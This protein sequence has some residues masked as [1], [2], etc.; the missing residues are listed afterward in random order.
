[1]HIPFCFHKCHYCD[2]YSLPDS[3]TGINGPAA[4]SDRQSAFVDRLLKEIRFQAQRYTLRPRTVF[5]GGGTP[6]LLEAELWKKILETMR[7]MGLLDDVAEFTVEAN[8]ETLHENLLTVLVQ[9]GVNRI[10][11]G[12]QSFN[13]THLKTLE[14]WHEPAS[15]TRAVTL[16]RK[17]GIANINLD[18]I[19]AIPGQTPDDVRDD[20]S[21]ALHLQPD[22]I[23]CYGLTYE[24]NTALTQRQRAG[25]I[26]PVDEEIERR[27]YG[28]VR[29]ILAQTG[30]E[31]YEIS[32]WARPGRQCLHNLVYWEN[33]SWLGFGPS[34]ASHVQGRRWK[35]VPHLG[36]YISSVA[37][38]PVADEEELDVNRHVGEVLMLR[39][40]LRAGAERSWLNALLRDDHARWD[41]VRDLERLGMLA[42]RDDHLQ[43]TEEGL[44][45]ADAVISQLL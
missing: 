18:L 30:Y 29:Q 40:R 1:M 7:Q 37:S 22:H 38:A 14:R 27:M 12:A 9:G 32:N 13:V 4:G 19:F 6:T 31:H 28:L 34:A 43:L 36:A 16:A 41:K 23:S 35:N 33:D 2:F 17:A 25:Q 8:P 11:I 15:V 5:F 45:V 10:S 44:Y 42:W 20:L 26:Q 21:Q 3:P 39:L 24:P